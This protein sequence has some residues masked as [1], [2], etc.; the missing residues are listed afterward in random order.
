MTEVGMRASADKPVRV[1]RRQTPTEDAK[2][3]RRIADQAIPRQVAPQP[4]QVTNDRMIPRNRR[5]GY[6][7]LLWLGP[8]GGSAWRFLESRAASA[9]PGIA[10]RTSFTIRTSQQCLRNL[11]D[12][13]PQ[14]TKVSD[15]PF[16]SG[17]SQVVGGLVSKNRFLQAALDEARQGVAEGGIPIGSVLVIDDQIVGRGHNR[18]VQNG[19]VILHAEMDAIE[20]AG[21]R[22]AAEYRRSVLYSTLSPC[23]MCSGAALLYRIPK[24]VIGE[25]RSFQGPESYLASRG[26]EL[27]IVDHPECVRLMEEFVRTHPSLWNEDIG[28]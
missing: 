4:P 16:R 8:L 28:I 9:S 1:L 24:V 2:H 22:S 18:R 21:R 10:Q 19:S 5:L 3:A 12:D 26:V 14:A 23:D 7:Q 17:V 27:S 11:A 13:R 25:N 20:N 6:F 15:E